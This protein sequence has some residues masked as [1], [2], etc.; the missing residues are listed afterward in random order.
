MANSVSG[1]SFETCRLRPNLKFNNLHTPWQRF[2]GFT[3]L[4]GSCF[5][6]ISTLQVAPGLEESAQHDSANKTAV[7]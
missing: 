2:G 3:S 6:V 7:T 1:L 4:W 5:R